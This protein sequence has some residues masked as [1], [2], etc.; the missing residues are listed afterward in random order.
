MRITRSK[1]F[2]IYATLLISLGLQACVAV[3]SQTILSSEKQK[4]VCWVAG[5][6]E[7]TQKEIDALLNCHVNWISQTPFG[8]QREASSSFI[9]TN[10]SSDRIWWGES[11][12]GI[13]L[14]TEIANRSGVRTLLKPHLWVRN[15]WP[16]DIEM[17]SD[18]AWQNWFKN[19]EAFILHYAALA[20][21]N[22]IEVFCI[23]TELQKTTTHEK[24]WRAVIA[25]IRSNYS[26]KL[27]YAAN[28]HEEFEHIKFWD[29][30]DYIGIQAYFSLTD[31]RDASLEELTKNW[32][33][34]LS[35]IERV[36]KEYNKPVIFTEI[37]YRSDAH[38]AIEPWIW[39]NNIKDVPLSDETQ[40]L[41]YQA[42][43]KA[44]WNKNWLV[45]VYF[46]KWYPHGTR[47]SAETDFT[48]Q[49]K[50]AEK[51][52]KENFAK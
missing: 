31:K 5:R 6:E 24:E 20:E 15:G 39:P 28:F 32:K 46:W 2:Y 12:N 38:A 35:A 50:P 10:F 14:T 40:A 34:P 45:G 36:H 43:F 33:A 52:M 26:G 25:K 13:S 29:A 37:G 49:G 8:W 4:G 1:Q 22:K 19:Y 51:V 16:G 48:P 47:R 17:K 23:G 42:F 41:C 7:I 3:E 18:T 44:A 11:D 9:G 27:I 21:K 30:L